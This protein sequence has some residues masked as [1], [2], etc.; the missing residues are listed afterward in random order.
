MK[1]YV[2]AQFEFLNDA[3]RGFLERGWPVI[4]GDTKM[5]SGEMIEPQTGELI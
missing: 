3:S 4:S 2:N 1:A 5:L